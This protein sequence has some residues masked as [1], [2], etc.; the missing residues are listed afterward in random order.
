MEVD[1]GIDPLLV[2]DALWVVGEWVAGNVSRKD[3]LVG[4]A[5]SLGAESFCSVGGVALSLGVSDSDEL[6]EGVK[7]VGDAVCD[8][9]ALSV[10]V[11]RMPGR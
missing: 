4:M 8:G 6:P 10:N 7:G 1:V 9:R 2:S 11:G 5:L 3:S